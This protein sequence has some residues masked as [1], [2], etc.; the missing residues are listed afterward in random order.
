MSARPVS[1]THRMPIGHSIFWV[2]LIL[3][4]SYVGVVMRPEMYRNV[5]ETAGRY[6][7]QTKEV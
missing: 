2:L 3:I 1:A 5:Q 7:K 6:R 4:V